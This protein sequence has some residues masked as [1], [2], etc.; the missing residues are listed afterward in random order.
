MFKS[1][2]LA[3]VLLSSACTTAQDTKIDTVLEATVAGTQAVCKDYQAIKTPVN[4]VALIVPVAAPIVSSVELYADAACN[5]ATALADP[6]TVA[7]LEQQIGALTATYMQLTG[8]PLATP[9]N[10]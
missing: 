8:K 10:S 5:S 4:T 6:T 1:A 2:I 7:W 9:T 3:T